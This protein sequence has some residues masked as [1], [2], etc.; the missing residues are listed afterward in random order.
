MLKAADAL[1]RAGYR[2]RV[3]STGS[4]GWNREADR[5][6]RQT[7]QWTW[8]EVRLDWRGAPLRRATSGA[9]Q[10]V[11]LGLVRT[12]GPARAP[13]AMV[14][15]ACS[16]AHRELVRAISA[17]PAELVYGGTA[18]ALAAAAAAAARLR[19]PYALDLEDFH[20]A[21]QDDGPRARWAHAVIEQVERRVLPGAGLLTAG[22]PAIA[23]AYAGKYGVPEPI[24]LN[25]TFPLPADPPD[26]APSPGPGLRLYWFSQTLGP[27]RGIEDAIGAVG[28]AEFPAELHLRGAPV[29]GYVDHLRGLAAT[30]APRLAIVHHEPEPPDPV[31]LCRRG[32]YDVG[33]ALEQG[34]VL[35]RRL[36]RTNKAFTY[37]LGGLAVAFTDTPGQ[38]PLAED[39]G[40][41]AVLYA[42]GDVKALGASLR[43]WAE[44]RELLA[45]A[46]KAAWQ[47]AERRWRWDHPSE[48]G[49]LISAVARL[50]GEPRR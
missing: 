38:R 11:A 42:P 12:V 16:R 44:D 5:R 49:A 47:A 18:G 10:R 25:N 35:N 40:P 6:L 26:L 7:R 29:R 14:A 17:R 31:E 24:T 50:L 8:S 27:G 45:R 37:I 2:V 34:H 48:E 28:S 3:V 15:A 23:E 20:T 39:L 9:W 41:G 19:A 43:A 1:D 22:S 13:L 32:S 33:L 36:C 4:V 46:K 30:S 21:E